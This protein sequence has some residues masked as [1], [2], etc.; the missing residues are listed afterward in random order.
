MKC[1]RFVRFLRFSRQLPRV[2]ATVSAKIS[3][4]SCANTAPSTLG[5]LEIAADCSGRFAT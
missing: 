5:L 1:L 4:E 2:P 3:S